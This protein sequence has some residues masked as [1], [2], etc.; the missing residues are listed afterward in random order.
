MFI[1]ARS[2]ESES[3][4]ESDVC[5]I[6]AGAAGITLALA[7][8]RGGRD[9]CLVESGGFASE[10]E[11]QE[12]YTGDVVD[13]DYPPLTVSRLRY[14]GGTTNHWGGACVPLEPFEFEKHDWVAHSGWPIRARDLAHYYERARS[15][16]DLTAPHY[17]FDPSEVG[18]AGEAAL[19]GASPRDFRTVVWRRTQPGPLRM[20]ERYAPDLRESSR[21]R[22]VHHANVTELV[23]NEAGSRIEAVAASTLSGRQ[24]RFSARSFVLCAGAIENARI[25]LLSDARIPGGI[26]NQNDLVG[27]YFADHGGQ[28]LGLI[29]IVTPRRR[30]REETFLRAHDSAGGDVVG[31]AATPAF[32]REH[33]TLGFA[34]M[35]FGFAN[36]LR[37]GQDTSEALRALSPGTDALAEAGSD[38]STRPGINFLYIAEKSPNPAS[39][40]FLRAEKDAL[41]LRR[42]ALDLNVTEADR[43]S[44]RES[45]RHFGA[46]VA[47]G[48]LARLRLE[49]FDGKPW[50][51][52]PGHHSG[53]TRMADDPKRGV[54]DRD[55]RIFGMSN[56]FVAGGSLYPTNGWEN[57]TLTIVA[58][59]LRLSEK[60]LNGSAD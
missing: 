5:L 21:I 58:L 12:L 38:P 35:A 6:G 59:A 44:V 51:G 13:G 17:R 16:L 33:R 25:L 57:T 37:A 56:L 53:T 3:S 19:L 47:R 4:F 60:L 31:F 2:V 9:V 22:C 45:S 24:L 49:S 15:F 32:R 36:P 40:V 34:V 43:R 27:R 29:Q 54:T 50:S 10:S 48:G 23:P 42:V 1:D 28:S 14:L 18:A 7:L 8:T 11:T 52:L 39:R 30:V 55:G 26:G 46:A 20:R 41:G